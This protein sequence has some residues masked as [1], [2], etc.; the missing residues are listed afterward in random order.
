MSDSTL[1]EQREALEGLASRPIYR[2]YMPGAWGNEDE[3]LRRKVAAAA[4]TIAE[5][6]S[7][8]VG[9]TSR[10]THELKCYP[11]P[12]QATVDGLKP[13]EWRRDDRGY[14]V[15]DRLRL[16]EWDPSPGFVG[17]TS[18]PVGK[19]G[20]YTGR[21]VTVDVVYISRGQFEIPTGF[22]VMAIRRLA[23]LEPSSF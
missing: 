5:L 7:G 1:K 10:R 14:A 21:E 12:F 23:P 2:D 6:E 20:D 16:R 8:K 11:E 18:G 17:P 3:I 22:C 9:P 19:D 13:Y 4:R 15:G